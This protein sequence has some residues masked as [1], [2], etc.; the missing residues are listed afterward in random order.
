MMSD[1]DQQS[2]GPVHEGQAKEI[3]DNA[4][5]DGESE[6][7]YDEKPIEE[8][9]RGFRREEGEF[10]REV[11]GITKANINEFNIYKGWA[12]PYSG[13]I[14]R[15]PI[16][17]AP[18][19]EKEIARVWRVYERPANYQNALK[20]LRDNHLIILQGQPNI[21]KRTTAIYLAADMRL[22]PETPEIHELPA[23]VDLVEHIKPENLTTGRYYLLEVLPTSRVKVLARKDWQMVASYLEKVGC[24][25]IVCANREIQ[26]PVDL[27][28]SMICALE[29]PDIKPRELVIRHLQHFGNFSPQAIDDCLGKKKVAKLLDSQVTPDSV[30]QLAQRLANF[31]AN[32]PDDE[33]HLEE[34]LRGFT[35]YAEANVQEW[36]EECGDDLEERAFRI[37]LAVFDGARYSAVEAASRD[38]AQ[39]LKLLQPASKPEGGTPS[40]SP[41]AR[42]RSTRLE[43]AHAHL[44]TIYVS[45]EYSDRSEVEVIR[46]ND[47]AYRPALL[48]CLWKEYDDFRE[49]FV[50]WLRDFDG[51]QIAAMRTRAATAVGVLAQ[52]DFEGIRAKVLYPWARQQERLYRAT[53]SHTL[54]KLVLDGQRTEEV[55][56]LIHSWSQSKDE[57]LVWAAVRAYALVGLCYPDKAM[58]HWR[59]IL[60]HADATMDF[61][62]TPTLTLSTPSPMMTSLVN[63]I[64]SLF[65]GAVEVP[66]CFQTVY[67]QLLVSLRGWVEAHNDPTVTT[68]IG[69]RLFL[70]LM[71]IRM[72]TESPD[73]D[74]KTSPPALLALL[75]HVN[76][77]GPY[78]DNL[79]WLLRRTLNAQDLG[80]GILNILRDW[81]VFVEAHE[82]L[83]PSLIQMLRS[84]IDPSKVLGWERDQLEVHFRWWSED[85]HRPLALAAELMHTLEL[86]A[87]L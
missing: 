59:N 12:P 52:L 39:R 4:V 81:V 49:A 38:L 80:Q 65:F 86:D 54:G 16:Q 61:K 10:F 73:S 51:I 55:L 37:A 40:P 18:V 82:N 53:L 60:E 62:L 24:Y 67:E 21:G 45:S 76:P 83:K 6:Q 75:A 11:V 32:D 15:Q 77:E 85:P 8:I 3:P 7:N 87:N 20:G 46:F 70:I 29:A 31:L 17:T 72:P 2:P 74:V 34:A 22:T 84:L 58:E 71:S 43:R 35:A 57:A 23:E 5:R 56:G 26:F 13:E 25:L 69:M 44:D 78:V 79:T 50:A 63:A 41:F 1:K 30:F 36:F 19:H 66:E 48:K 42:K 64:L 9:Q 68:Q 47:S 33:T 14:R 27:P 28:T